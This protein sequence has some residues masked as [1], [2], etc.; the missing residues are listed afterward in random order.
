MARPISLPGPGRSSGSR[1]CARRPIVLSMA[2]HPATRGRRRGRPPAFGTAYF[3]VRDP[4][5]FRADLRA[6][7]AAGYTWVLL[8]FT[9]DD[10]LWEGTTFALQ[11]AF[12]RSLGLRTVISLWG[13]TEFGGEGVRTDLPTLE[14]LARA[15]ET[16]ADVLHVDE[17]RGAALPGH[18]LLDAWGDDS[19]VW[20]TIQADRGTWLDPGIVRRVAVVGATAYDG[21]VRQRLRA[22]RAFRATTGRLDLAWVQAFRIQAGEEAVVGQMTAAAAA[23]APVVGIWAWRGSTGRG[24]LR[25]AR[26]RR[27]EEAVQAAI[28]AYR[29]DVPT[30][31]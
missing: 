22:L 1:V 19:R 9:H 12:A 20:L 7:A 28:A 27:V 24:E 25:S 3:G 5:H 8:P 21:D 11:V 17:P 14:W 26:P 30:A 4:S 15:K 29:S 16:G 23:V 2:A 18:H 6:I 10:A 31:A 13:G